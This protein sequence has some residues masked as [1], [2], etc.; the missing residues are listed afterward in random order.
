MNNYFTLMNIKE[1]SIYSSVMMPFCWSSKFF[2]V[3]LLKM[4]SF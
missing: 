4:M 3:P 2:I 1:I